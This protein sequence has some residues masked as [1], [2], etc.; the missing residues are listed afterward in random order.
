[1]QTLAEITLQKLNPPSNFNPVI[2]KQIFKDIK[3]LRKQCS[4]VT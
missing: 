3:E 2:L 1:M 4:C